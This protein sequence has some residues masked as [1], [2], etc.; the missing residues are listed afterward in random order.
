MANIAYRNA[1]GSIESDNDYGALG[2]TMKNGDRAYG[3]YQVMGSNVPDWTEK[4]YGTRLTPQQFLKNQ[5]AQ[6]AVFDNEFGGYADKYGN[7]QDAAAMWFS[8]RPLSRAGNASDGYITTPAYV[9]RFTNA[10]KGASQEDQGTMASDPGALTP[11]KGVL[12]PGTGAGMINGMNS[13]QI[14]GQGLTGLGA[15]LAGISSPAQAASLNQSA[16]AMQK[17]SQPRYTTQYDKDSGT[18]FRINN[19]NGQV[20]FAQNPQGSTEAERAAAKEAATL[21]AKTGVENYNQAV[22]AAQI[23]DQKLADLQRLRTVVNDPNVWQGGG[24][25]LAASTK[26]ALNAAGFDVKGKTS[27]DIFQ[28]LKTKAQLEN[29]KLLKGAISNYEDKLL[30]RAQGLSLNNTREANLAALDALERIYTHQK[31]LGAKARE[32]AAAHHGLLDAGWNDLVAN[33][34]TLRLSDPGAHQAPAQ[35]FKTPTGV[36]WSF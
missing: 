1:I 32:Y 21:Q 22:D 27:T 14:V 16:A 20:E 12:F 36:N 9:T 6:D 19:A 29:S 26:D 2:P 18:F 4:H 30:G 28:A 17:Q 11:D 3:R 34:P 24:G 15:A 10:L 25:E 8:G 5:D 35:S 13:G 33:E 23:A 31:T 7:P